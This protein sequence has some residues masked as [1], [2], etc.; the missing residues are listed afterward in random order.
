MTRMPHSLA[1]LMLAALTSAAFLPAGAHAQ[2]STAVEA[3][4]HFNQDADSQDGVS[5]VP[6]GGGEAVQ[7]DVNTDDVDSAAGGTTVDGNGVAICDSKSDGQ[8]ECVQ[9][10]SQD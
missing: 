1:A 2:S 3:I 5:S 7:P 9:G 10:D 8:D 6:I 4:Q